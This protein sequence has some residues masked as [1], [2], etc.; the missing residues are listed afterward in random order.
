VVSAGK[1]GAIIQ[2][3]VR[4]RRLP[5][6]V[7]RSLPYGSGIS[8]VENIVR[9]VKLAL[10]IHAVI[11]A[12]SDCPEDDDV[13]SVARAAGAE[14]LR[15]SEHDVL[16]RFH[17]AAV[18]HGLSQVVRLTA[19]NPF[20]DPVFLDACLE[21]HGKGKADYTKTIGLPLG[22]N[23]EAISFPALD[24]LQ[25]GVSL[26]DEREHVTLHLNKNPANFI[27]GVIDLGKPEY[28]GLRLTIDWESDYAL[29]CF[30]YEQ[31]YTPRKI[32]NLDDIIALLNK[33]PWARLINAD[34]KKE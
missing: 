27:V 5:G 2:A 13:A 14:V 12:T 22:M 11:V 32:F 23:C 28:E 15:G 31:L 10:G 1:V 24:R 33:H 8:I 30:I 4:S 9:R 29:A 6:K 3:R 7:L 19:D 20:V 34:L 16:D 26:S 25:R 17:K 21:S 18:L